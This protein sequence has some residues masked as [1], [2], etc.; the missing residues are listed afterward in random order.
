MSGLHV[1][2]LNTEMNSW[3]LI[4]YTQELKS[5]WNY[6]FLDLYFPV[7]VACLSEIW[8]LDCISA[9]FVVCL[10]KFDQKYNE[11]FIK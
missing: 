8:I 4:A 9:L 2:V 10:C 6:F 11:G 1:H 7:K 5:V 3:N